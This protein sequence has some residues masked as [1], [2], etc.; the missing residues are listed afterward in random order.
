MRIIY[1]ILG[2]E[3]I[4]NKGKR[5]EIGEVSVIHKLMT[6]KIPKVIDRCFPIDHYK[7]LRIITLGMPG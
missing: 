6:H 3:V 4:N 7:A 5:N 2:S 1:S